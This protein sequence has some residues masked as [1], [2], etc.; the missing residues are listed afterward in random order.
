MERLA[1]RG[2]TGS[3]PKAPR[4]YMSQLKM[5]RETFGRLRGRLETEDPLP[6]P[7]LPENTRERIKRALEK[8]SRRAGEQTTRKL[9]VAP[10]RSRQPIDR[11]QRER[12]LAL[13]R[14]NRSH[15]ALAD[16]ERVHAQL[17]A[18]LYWDQEH[19][20]VTVRTGTRGGPRSS[21]SRGRVL[22]RPRLSIESSWPNSPITS[23]HRGSRCPGFS[24]GPNRGSGGVFRGKGRRSLPSGPA[25][26]PTWAKPS[27]P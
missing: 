4:R 11:F 1:L 23:L 24:A 12:C 26:T 17:I 6:G 2:R 7:S 15:M 19:R 20:I 13:A 27:A 14:K 16:D 22:R 9:A 21:A 5:I 10:N 18:P 3:T 25:F 8:Q